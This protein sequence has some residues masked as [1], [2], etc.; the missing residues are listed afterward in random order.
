MTDLRAELRSVL[1]VLLADVAVGAAISLDALGEAIGTRAVSTSEIELMITCIEESGRT[2]SAP[3]AGSGEGKLARVVAAA[4]ALSAELGRR[5]T[6]REV[7]ERAGLAPDEVRQA[8]MLL[9]IMQ[10]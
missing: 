3:A 7:A 5:P 6:S 10:R 4:R 8:L 1:N 2:V 9:T